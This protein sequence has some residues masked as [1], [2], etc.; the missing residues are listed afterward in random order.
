MG[1]VKTSEA[2]V[3]GERAQLLPQGSLS[4][5]KRHCGTFENYSL[6]VLAGGLG[7]EGLVPRS[8]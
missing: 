2:Q 3:P 4:A 1:V 5:N 6:A 7:R 8:M